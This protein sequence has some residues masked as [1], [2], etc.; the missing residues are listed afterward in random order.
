MVVSDPVFFDSDRSVRADVHCPEG[1]VVT[2]GGVR[3]SAW[4]I[5]NHIFSIESSHPLDDG[6]GWHADV[7]NVED[8][9]GLFVQVYALCM[10]FDE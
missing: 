10:T 6:S 3:G 7:F 4:S 1:K 9:N 2:G 8:S 5:D